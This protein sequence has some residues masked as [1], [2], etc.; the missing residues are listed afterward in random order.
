MTKKLENRVAI[1]TGAGHGIGK[2]YA[3][4][5]AEEGAKVVIAELDAV[6]AKAVAE[7][8]NA[9]GH[10]ALGLTVDVSKAGD[11]N[12]M[13]TET[14]AK[15][16]R[17]DIL[18][19]NAAIFATVPMSRAGF[20]KI[21]EDEWDAM[22]R[23]NV[24]GSWLAARA[25]VPQM[26]EQNYGKIINISS[27]TAFNGM[28]TRIHYT[29]SKAAILGFTRTLASEIGKHNICVN[30]VAPGSTLAEEN[31]DEKI[32]EFRKNAA[33][34]RALKRVQEPNDLTGAIVFFASSD[35]DFITGQTLL[36]DGGNFMH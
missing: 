33:R 24:K 9:A 16:G 6:A 10:Q 26:Q 1:V 13:A 22:M 15:F 2:A 18:V 4:R 12:R 21:E 34:G 25:V 8:L 20:D 28:P 7:E 23:V 11:L 14:V 27:S 29:S 36:V 32:L 3:K 30:C 17:I 19:N 5:L 31:P 35:S